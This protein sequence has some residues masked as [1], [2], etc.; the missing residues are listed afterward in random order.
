MVPPYPENGIAFEPAP[1]EVH[2]G[3]EVVVRLVL[4]QRRGLGLVVDDCRLQGSGVGQPSLEVEVAQDAPL[5][6]WVGFRT[7][8]AGWGLTS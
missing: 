3:L 7:S 8:S 2:G 4:G 6:S 1:G 5:L